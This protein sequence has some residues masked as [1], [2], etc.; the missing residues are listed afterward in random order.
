MKLIKNN[1]IY[2]IENIFDSVL[3]LNKFGKKGEICYQVCFSDGHLGSSEWCTKEE[4]KLRGYKIATK[5]EEILYGP[6]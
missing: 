6:R 4:L 1:R 2:T 3:P 5:A